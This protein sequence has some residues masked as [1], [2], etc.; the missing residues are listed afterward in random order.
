MLQNFGSILLQS[1]A[2]DF[3]RDQ[4]L[5]V[6]ERGAEEILLKSILPNL[7]LRLIS[8]NV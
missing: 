3:L 7:V 2:A 5:F 4:L 1:N 6:V 8:I